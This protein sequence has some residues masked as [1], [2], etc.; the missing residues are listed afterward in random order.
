MAAL[1]GGTD[2]RRAALAEL[3]PVIDD[4]VA[5][6]EAG[7]R[8]TDGVVAALKAAG[9]YRMAMPAAWG[10]PQLPMLEVLDVVEQL[11]Y[12]EGAV[13]WCAMI[14]CDGAFYSAWL[15]DA[16]GKAMYDDLDAITAGWVMPAGSATPVDDGF[17]L[18]GRWSFGSGSTHA[19][20][21]CSGGLVADTFEWRMFFVP[22]A[23]VNVLPGTWDTTGLRGSGSYD[24]A[25][26]DVFVPRE[27]TFSFADPPQRPDSLYAHRATFAV[28]VAA[29]P[30]G[31]ARRA[32]D[33]V[34]AMAETKMVMPQL[35]PLRDLPGTQEAIARA[36]ALVLAN[37]AWFH[38]VVGR[39]TDR[40]DAGAELDPQ[41]RRHLLLS[42]SSAIQS[43]RQAIELLAEVVG[44]DSVKRGHRLER[45]R[46][47]AA[48]ASTHIVG[49]AFQPCGR[50]LLGLDPEHPLF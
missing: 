30:T 48:T 45:I 8:L 32:I 25:V 34:R 26:D 14:G 2:E 43:S 35:V 12:L 13:G 31:L 36:E 19:D 10:G 33:E 29:V 17:R 38:D 47:D 5:E 9:A 50:A 7:A 22:R 4:S 41:I 40:L 15:D 46:R 21:F 18:S 44:S 1:T 42:A 20:W 16:I 24:Y 39:L 27:R 23:E 37:R 49:R 28:K 11:S 6:M 3:A